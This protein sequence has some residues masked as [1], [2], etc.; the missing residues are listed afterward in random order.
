MHCSPCILICIN[1]SLFLYIYT[2]ISIASIS[3]T[4]RMEVHSSMNTVSLITAQRY[5]KYLWRQEFPAI[6]CELICPC[7]PAPHPRPSSSTCTTTGTTT[8]TAPCPGYTTSLPCPAC[9]MACPLWWV[10]AYCQIERWL[11]AKS[12][13]GFLPSQVLAYCQVRFWLTA[14]SG[15]GLLSSFG[16]LFLV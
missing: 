9:T 16:L 6:F 13:F 11:T 12:S 15:F 7:V 14:K 2:S 5:G 3:F 8:T 10:L 1:F 4:G